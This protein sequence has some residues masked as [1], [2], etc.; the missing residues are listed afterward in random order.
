MELIA[1]FICSPNRKEI[2]DQTLIF[3]SNSIMDDVYY[4]ES[5]YTYVD[6]NDFWSDIFTDDEN[7]IYKL[8]L[9]MEI[10]GYN[11]YSH[12]YGVDEYDEDIFVNEVIIKDKLPNFRELRYVA[13]L[14]K[15]ENKGVN[16]NGNR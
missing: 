13:E 16:K 1:E 15:E 7:G 12:Y 5:V 9:K 2:Y 10:K 3:L 11:S 4:G 6:N 14:I 8:V